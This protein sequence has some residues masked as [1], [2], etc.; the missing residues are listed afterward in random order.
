MF[1]EEHDIASPRHP[2]SFKG[3]AEVQQLKLPVGF[4]VQLDFGGGADDVFR[5]LHISL[6]DVA[7]RH[8]SIGAAGEARQEGRGN[9][10]P[11]HV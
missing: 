10:E 1:D 7:A 2:L 4:Q 9:D 6:A 5:P 8:A 11:L 3:H